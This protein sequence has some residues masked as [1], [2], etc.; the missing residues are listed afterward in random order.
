MF[1]Y[2]AAL[3]RKCAVIA[4]MPEAGPILSSWKKQTVDS[5]FSKSLHLIP[6]PLMTEP[7]LSSQEGIP[8]AVENTM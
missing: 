1:S 5:S 3:E 8:A 4:S 7:V 6:W 2:D